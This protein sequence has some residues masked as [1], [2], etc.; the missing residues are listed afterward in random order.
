MASGAAKRYAQAVFELAKEQGT[1]D[2]WESDLALLNDLMDDEIVARF[3]A[4]PSV[5][6]E[7]K[8]ETVEQVLGRSQQEARNLARLLIERQRMNIVRDLYQAFT[9]MRLEEQGIAIAEVTTAEELGLEGQEI[10][11]QRL[12]AIVGKQVQLRMRIDPDL[13][14][15][16]VA[17]VG[18]VLID[19][20]VIN[21]L[22]RLRARLAASA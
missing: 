13:I 10:V 17:R 22:R 4:S 8:L 19:G 6:P 12:E 7:Q 11:K 3:F 9:E 15:G 21:Q 14:G 1:L 16:V 2:A 5:S 18:D 20:S